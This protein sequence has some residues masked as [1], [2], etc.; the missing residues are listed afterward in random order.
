MKKNR[1]GTLMT[2]VA[3]PEQREA[4]TEIVFREST[5]IGIRHQEL[6]RECLDR[7]MVTVDDQPRP[8]ALQGGAA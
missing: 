6:S 3:K 4:M 5:T 1:P 2:I 7:E 8:G